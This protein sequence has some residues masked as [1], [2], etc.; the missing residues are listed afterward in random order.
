MWKSPNLSQKIPPYR[1]D[2]EDFSHLRGLYEQDSARKAD[3][4]QDDRTLLSS[5]SE[6]GNY[7]GWVSASGWVCLSSSRPL[8]V[9]REE[10]CLQGLPHPLLCPQGARTDPQNHALGRAKNDILFTNWCNKTHYQIIKNH[11]ISNLYT[12]FSNLFS[13]GSVESSYLCSREQ[14]T[15]LIT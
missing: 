8:Q 2:M 13:D 9:W 5:S 10:D 7:A 12:P 11:P 6:G 3:R 1:T 4:P 15:V 14:I